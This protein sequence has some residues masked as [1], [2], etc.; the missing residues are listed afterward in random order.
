[1]TAKR[2]LPMIKAP[3]LLFSFLLPSHLSCL[4]FIRRNEVTKLSTLDPAVQCM[5]VTET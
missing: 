5:M 2:T 1:M 3:S 4:S